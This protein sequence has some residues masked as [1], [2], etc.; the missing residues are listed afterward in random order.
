MQ[1]P[2]TNNTMTTNN[3]NQPET[4]TPT[5]TAGQ[6]VWV[7]ARVLNPKFNKKDQIYLRFAEPLAAWNHN[8][9]ELLVYTT[10]EILQEYG[11]IVPQNT[12]DCTKNL[13]LCLTEEEF[14]H[15]KDCLYSF[16]ACGE[17]EEKLNDVLYDKIRNVKFPV[18]ALLP[19]TPHFDEKT[20]Q[21]AELTEQNAECWVRATCT[22]TTDN[23]YRV[24]LAD[25]LTESTIAYIDPEDVRFTEPT[26]STAI[27][28]LI[29]PDR[30]RKFRK[31]DKVQRRKELEGRDLSETC[32]ELPFDEIFT[33]LEDEN[34]AWNIKVKWGDK[35]AQGGFIYFE[36]VE[37]APE[38][39]FFIEDET[40][41]DSYTINFGTPDNYQ[42]VAKLD[43][44]FYTLEEAWKECEKLSKK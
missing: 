11:V 3:N 35:T 42:F 19:E 36:L 18:R 6:K 44:D 4:N 17:Y 28:E 16:V 22:E 38:E 5:F 39:K 29:E 41:Y 30:T 15:L 7:N 25:T 20:P 21:N 27:I 31:G 9:H 24:E 10:E 37:P 32:P 14:K 12:Q 23:G 43:T 8:V 13:I 33:V 40:S 2:Q 34:E 26:H 1:K